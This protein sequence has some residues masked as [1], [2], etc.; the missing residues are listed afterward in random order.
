VATLQQKIAES[1]LER[2]AKRPGIDAAMV[3]RIGRLLLA[4]K[5]PKVDDFV[6]LFSQ[7]DGGSAK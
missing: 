5:K 6:Q 4:N 1:F 3:E 2:L 7:K